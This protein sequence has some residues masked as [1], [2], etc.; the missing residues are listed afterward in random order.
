MCVAQ[1]SG[2]NLWRP[3]GNGLDYTVHTLEI[4]GDG[5]V[6]AGGFFRYSGV[7]SVH[8]NAKYSGGAWSATY[9]QAAGTSTIG[10]VGEIVRASNGD[11]YYIITTNTTLQVSIP[12]YVTITNIGT[13]S[14][15]PILYVKG[16]GTLTSIT[17]TKTTQGINL[18]FDIAVNEEVEFDFGKGTITSN[19]RGNV[20][21]SISP[22]S[23]V[24]SILLYP[25][26]NEFGILVL[27]DI[28][29]VAQLRWTPRHWSVDAVVAAKAL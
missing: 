4:D 6:L 7:E 22:G 24:R 19:V 20:L 27:N 12:S 1:W 16:P 15:F 18:D 13:A 26:D 14:S 8:K 17:N 25:K 21:Y 29:A 23:E 10:S 2:G 5:G 9:L 11:I 28:N 3:M